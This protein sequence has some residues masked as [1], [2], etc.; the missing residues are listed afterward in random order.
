[1]SFDNAMCAMFEKQGAVQ[2]SEAVDRAPSNTPTGSMALDADDA[3]SVRGYLSGRLLSAGPAGVMSH[4]SIAGSVIA[5]E[6]GVDM[7]TGNTGPL[8]DGY[9]AEPQS[10]SPQNYV[11]G[12]PGGGDARDADPRAGS[13]T[14]GG[15]GDRRR[16]GVARSRSWVQQNVTQQAAEEDV[17]ER[18]EGGAQWPWRAP[19]PELHRAVQP[20][21]GNGTGRGVQPRSPKFWQQPVT[22]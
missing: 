16:G 19:G 9:V 4:L 13:E 7:D 18:G 3:A 1:M 10:Q 14:R 6:T 8:G 11:F 12:A 20:V 2:D 5:E 21:A 15:G 22:M 17:P